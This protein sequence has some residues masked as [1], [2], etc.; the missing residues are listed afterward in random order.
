[1]LRYSQQC[2]QSADDADQYTG[3]YLSAEL[4]KRDGCQHNGEQHQHCQQSFT[5]FQGTPRR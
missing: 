1:M 5:E 4:Q 2:S 3:Q